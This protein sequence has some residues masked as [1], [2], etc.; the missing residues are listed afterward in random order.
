MII[1]IITSISIC[2][3]II[4]SGYQFLAIE[5]DS[6]TSTSAILTFNKNTSLMNGTASNSAWSFEIQS[7][8]KTLQTQYKNKIHN[9]HIQAKLIIIRE[10]LNNTL[11][12]PINNTLPLFLA[13]AFPEYANSILDAWS[14]MDEYEQWLIT[15]N[16]TLME[17]NELGRS[18]MLWEKRH[19]LFPLSATKIWNEERDKYETAQFKL[20]NEIDYLDQSMDTSTAE[21]IDRLTTSF[22]TANTMF[23]NASSQEGSIH[24][25]TIASVL[26][27]LASVQNELKELDPTSRQLEIDAIRRELGYNEGSIKKMAELDEKRNQR[28]RNGYS[29]MESRKLLT[30][31]NTQIPESELMKLR[32][33]FFGSSA[34]TIAKEEAN[35]FY[36]FQRP[37]YY[38]R[39]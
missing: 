23:M 24:K 32:D 8:I 17:L 30:E 27:G 16:R 12:P 36:R 2:L 29:Y 39:N 34:K 9:T 26:F 19:E 18:G 1:K 15:N 37:R 4:L 10:K 6:N 38:G 5:D 22:Q 3:L 31:N 35:G 13:D 28:W 20:H 11:P 25:N 33:Q 7:I 14:K 21:K